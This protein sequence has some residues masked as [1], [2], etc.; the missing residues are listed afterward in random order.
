VPESVESE[1][2][3]ASTE[4]TSEP[5]PE[6]AA[7]AARLAVLSDEI[8]RLTLQN[9][10]IRVELDAA[11]QTSSEWREEMNVT[12][13]EGRFDLMGLLH[14]RIA[15]LEEE[16]DA[17]QYS[18]PVLGA[19]IYAHTAQLRTLERWFTRREIDAAND[20]LTLIDAQLSVLPKDSEEA[21]SLNLR[22]ETLLIDRNF[23][24]EQLT[25]NATEFEQWDARWGAT[26][27]G[28]SKECTSIKEAGCGPT[29][30]AIVLNYLYQEDP[31]GL[32][33]SGNF[34]IVTPPQTAKYAETHGRV[35]NSGTAGDT[36]VSQVQTGF[37]GFQGKSIKFSSVAEQLNSGNLVIFLCK[38][39][40]GKKAGGASKS[41]GGHFMV[42]N[43]VN[44]DGSIYNVLDPGNAETSDIVTITKQN[45]KSKTGGFW[46]VQRQ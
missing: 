5:N 44:S 32:A 7:R 11:P 10:N 34:E 6:N 43:G 39:C 23:K 18:D 38:D 42:L 26:R 35:C 4:Q 36:M 20:E 1:N 22:K 15:L 29:S 16:M 14:E 41:Y 27:Y 40:T 3:G 28:A 33:S 25:S 13:N 9:A 8:N 31:E 37:P 19:E 17:L 24:A 46:I 21:Q 12:L 45:L 2:T 30:L